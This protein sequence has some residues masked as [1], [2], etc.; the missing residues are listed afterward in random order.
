MM[1]K[2]KSGTIIL[3]A[4]FTIVINNTNKTTQSCNTSTTPRFISQ[5]I[6]KFGKRYFISYKDIIKSYIKMVLLLDKR[7]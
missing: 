1:I 2:T 5:Y 6:T 4:L 7:T 3:H